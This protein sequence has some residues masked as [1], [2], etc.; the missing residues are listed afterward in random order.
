MTRKKVGLPAVLV[1]LVSMSLAACGSTS[2]A[3]T[4]I[5]QAGHD[6]APT[7][8]DYKNVSDPGP[9][10]KPLGKVE[11][12]CK[13]YDP[14]IPS[15]SPN[16]YWYRIASAPWDNHDYAVANTFFNGDPINGPYSHNTDFKV[17]NC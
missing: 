13:V 16:G 14:S 17:P 6:G 10:I 12:S 9:R 2:H 11:V 15:A 4:H 5:E 1:V 8:A 7:F 3:A